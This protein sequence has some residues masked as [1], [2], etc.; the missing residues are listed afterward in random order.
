MQEPQSGHGKAVRDRMQIM[1]ENSEM[2][3]RVCL[4]VGIT[5]TRAWLMRGSEI[6]SRASVMQGIRG[7]FITGSQQ[8]ALQGIDGAVDECLKRAGI[9]VDGAPIECLAA[10]GM[11][12]SELGPYHVPHLQGP[13]GAPELAAGVVATRHAGR[14]DAPLFLVPGIRF[15]V[16]GACDGNDAMRG[17]ETLIAGLLALQRMAPGDALL[18]LGSHWK[19][20]GTDALGRIADS[21]TSVGGELIFAIAR[22]TILKGSLPPERPLE[23]ALPDVMTGSRRARE[24]GLARALFLTR[25]DAQRAGLGVEGAYWQVAGAVIGDSAAGIVKRAGQGG[26][27]IAGFAPLAQAWKHVLGEEGVDARLLGEAEVEQ[28][29]CAGLVTIV[30]AMK[31]SGR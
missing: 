15:G 5:Q 2:R 21:F 30:D 4:D 19:L 7:G 27:R 13:C 17:E 1:P 25:M 10:A 29:F 3:L 28:A 23:V 22:E 20:I 14:L 16:D 12:T 8:H 26:V 18:N 11:V 24:H 31:A 6:V 9:T